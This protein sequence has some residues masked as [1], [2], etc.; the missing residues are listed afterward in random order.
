MRLST[1]T[2]WHKQRSAY[3]NWGPASWSQKGVPFQISSNSQLA[4][5]Y[6]GVALEFLKKESVCFLELGGGSGKFAYHFLRELVPRVEKLGLPQVRYVLTDI[7]EKNVLFWQKHPLLIPYFESGVLEAAVY[8][9]LLSPPLLDNP[10]VIANYFF[11]SIEQD[12]FRVERGQLMEGRISED[13]TYSYHPVDPHNYYP[14]FP[15]LN[16]LLEEYC[17]CLD[18][19]TFLIPI[20]AIQ[21]LRNLTPSFVLAGDKGFSI[22]GELAALRDPELVTHGTFSFPVNFHAIGEYVRKS[23]GS[24]MPPQKLRPVFSVHGFCL[25]KTTFSFHELFTPV[26]LDLSELPETLE[27]EFFPLSR[28]EA[29]LGYNFVHLYE[30]L[31][32]FDLATLAQKRLEKLEILP[33]KRDFLDESVLQIGSMQGTTPIS[34]QA[35]EG[36]GTFDQILFFSPKSQ[37]SSRQIP[38]LLVA[39]GQKIV[40]EI[41][42]QFSGL[43]QIVYSNQDLDLLFSSTVVDPHHYLHFLLE[44]EKKKQITQEQLTRALHKLVDVGI[45]EEKAL[46]QIHCLEQ[47]ETEDLFYYFLQECLQKHM[48]EGAE[49]RGYFEGKTTLFDDPRLFE[50]IISHPMIDY[51]EEIEKVDGCEFLMVTITSYSPKFQ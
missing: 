49:F 40:Q 18:L 14:E 43:T 7:A 36:L 12:L 9:P 11:D 26:D 20:G 27:A 19:A 37:T 3:C 44:L 25:K 10:F 16:V 41:E 1:S 48:K 31:G 21:T 23:G 29:L 39:E 50:E 38:S 33:S 2:L 46:Q 28:E 35:L 42:K 51:H 17:G 24:W 4:K 30:K 5:Q 47:T 6:A 32:Q 13:G 8:N 22:I 15:E 45:L 34:L